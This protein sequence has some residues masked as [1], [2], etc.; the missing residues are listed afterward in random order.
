VRAVDFVVACSLTA[1]SRE[2]VWLGSAAIVAQLT[3]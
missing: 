3:A 1:M 2:N